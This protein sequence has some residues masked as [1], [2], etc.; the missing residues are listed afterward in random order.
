MGIERVVVL[1]HGDGSDWST[2][3]LHVEMVGTVGCEV[4]S[5]LLAESR[6]GCLDY[7][8]GC[9]GK[10][11]IFAAYSAHALLPLLFFKNCS[12]ADG[13]ETNR[14]FWVAEALPKETGPRDQQEVANEAR[15]WYG[16]HTIA[17][18]AKAYAKVLKDQS[19]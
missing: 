5:R 18:T 17:V 13:L 12:E 4:A 14:H 2:T 19:C 16:T 1:G 6:V 15:R 10:S 11:G 7:F 8:D 3:G 9:L